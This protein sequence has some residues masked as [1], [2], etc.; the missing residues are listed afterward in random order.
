MMS[1]DEVRARLVDLLYRELPP[2]AAGDVEK[3]LAGCLAC[4]KAR[5][6][7]A[8][9][10]RLLDQAGPPPEIDVDFARLY[11]E[12]HRRQRHWGRHWRRAAALAGLAAAILLLLLLKLEV[13]LDGHQLVLRWGTAPETPAPPLPQFSVPAPDR[14]AAAQVSPD[15]LRL[16]RELIHALAAD[17][18]SGDRKTQEALRRL[19]ARLEVLRAQA[20]ARWEMT[21]RFASALNTIQISLTESG[22]QR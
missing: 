19:G 15:D 22:G 9:V 6:A 4:Q 8:G 20:Q 2:A 3:H 14:E 17:V 11:E 12:A 21:E 18:E 13:R 5:A 1:C 7:L 10:G 16:T